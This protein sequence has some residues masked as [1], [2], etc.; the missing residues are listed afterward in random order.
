MDDEGQFE[1]HPSGTLRGESTWPAER[2][3]GM[4][5]AEQAHRPLDSSFVQ[6]FKHA[7]FTDEAVGETFNYLD[8]DTE[9]SIHVSNPT[10]SNVRHFS[11]LVA[12]S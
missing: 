10:N 8:D 5:D 6:G 1:Q 9:G 3:P 2:I 7:L 11:H 12:I 4:L